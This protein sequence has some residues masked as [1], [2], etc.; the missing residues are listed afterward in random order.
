[1]VDLISCSR[2]NLISCLIKIRKPLK[3]NI[4]HLGWFTSFAQNLHDVVVSQNFI[5]ELRPRSFSELASPLAA[6]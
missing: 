5:I 2:F 6:W 1:M 4:L 3:G